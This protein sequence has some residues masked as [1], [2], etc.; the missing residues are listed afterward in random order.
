MTRFA[1]I[2][3]GILSMAAPATAQ[4]ATD[5]PAGVPLAMP[6]TPIGEI[7]YGRPVMILGIVTAGGP[8]HFTLNDGGAAIIVSAGP[9]WDRAAGVKEG[10]RV[11]VIGQ[12]DRFGSGMFMA[13]SITT[14]EGRSVSVTPYK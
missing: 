13:G 6:A 4:Q 1:A 7:P 2:L 5:A 10:D 8:A 11:Q 14:T 3:V 12:L 9:G